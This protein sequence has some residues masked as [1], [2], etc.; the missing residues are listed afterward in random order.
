MGRRTI[1]PAREDHLKTGS[2]VT[3]RQ[4]QGRWGSRPWLAIALLFWIIPLVA[5][6]PDAVMRGVVSDSEGIPLS[7]AKLTA[8]RSETNFVQTAVTDSQGEY[9]FGLLPRGLYSL[10][11]EMN[12]YTGLEKR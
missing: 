10:K 5:Q 12:G 8:T 3:K 1:I 9:Y 2:K 11:V 6:A 7:G 4:S